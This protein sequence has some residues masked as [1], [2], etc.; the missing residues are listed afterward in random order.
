L[1]LA[2]VDDWLVIVHWKLVHDFPIDWTLPSEVD[3]HSPTSAPVDEPDE[4][5]VLDPPLELP[6]EL[7]GE[8]VL[9]ALKLQAD[10]ATSTAASQSIDRDLMTFTWPPVRPFITNLPRVAQVRSTPVPER[11]EIPRKPLRTPRDC[12][13]LARHLSGAKVSRDGA[14]DRRNRNGSARAGC[15]AMSSDLAKT[16]RVGW[17]SRRARLE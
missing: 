5:G 10:A 4:G 9:P 11:P 7:V 17:G 1:P 3:D 16:L 13:S 12:R 14:H 6:P 2:D 8:S 15:R